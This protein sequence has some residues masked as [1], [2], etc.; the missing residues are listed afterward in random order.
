S[1]SDLP[2]WGPPPAPAPPP[3]AAAARPE[4]LRFGS[5]EARLQD[6]RPR[7][8]TLDPETTPFRGVRVRR[9][10]NLVFNLSSYAHL[11]MTMYR[12]AG[13]RVE[14]RAFDDLSQV[15]ALPEGVV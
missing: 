9:Q 2:G 11:L 15:A 10:A 6:V 4:R 14:R 5:Y 8:E 3:V 1:L 12:Q 7:P 13:G